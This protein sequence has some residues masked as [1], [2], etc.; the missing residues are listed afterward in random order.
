[1][2]LNQQPVGLVGGS[3]LRTALATDAELVIIADNQ[4]CLHVAPL[5]GPD[6]WAD[7]CPCRPVIDENGIIQHCLLH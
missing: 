7:R 3:Q 1:M 6:H 2:G 5:V 4:G